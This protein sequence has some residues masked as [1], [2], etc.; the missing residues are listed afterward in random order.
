M[1]RKRILAAVFAVV[2]LVS[3]CACSSEKKLD[4]EKTINVTVLNGAT[5]FGAAK[6][7]DDAKNKKTVLNYNVSVE[8]DAS[9]VNAA[10]IS[11]STDI[12][13]IPTNAAAAVYNKT[14]GKIKVVAVNTLGVLYV[15]QNGDSVKSFEDLRGKTLYVPGQGSN[16]QYVTEYLCEKNG[17]KVGTDITLDYS[18]TAP[19]DLRTAVAAGKVELAVLP[20]PMVTIAKSANAELNTAL[21]L[22][23]EWDKVSGSNSLTQ[24]C[25]AVT[26]EFAEN[27][28]AEL[29]KFLEE[30]EASVEYVKSNPEEG[31]QLVAAAGIF[32]K[33]PVAA[34][35]IP[36]CNMCFITGE[37]MK[38][39]LSEFYTVLEKANAA[40]IGGKLP[41]DGLYYTGK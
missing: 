6:L 5:G 15:V 36:N 8:T 28:P 14:Q 40:A 30:Y 37:S 38:T 19:A 39:A 2:M 33:A 7:I 16:P 23:A 3:L 31:G 4:T 24:G 35:A 25:I 18:Y 29:E 9:N 21:D 17:L 22:N 13:A 27:N 34:K 41:D 32:E 26:A 1:M 11:G 10:L 20:E 12:A